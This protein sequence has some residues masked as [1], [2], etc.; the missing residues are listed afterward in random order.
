MI[1][2]LRKFFG[3]DLT[4]TALTSRINNELSYLEAIFDRSMRPIDILELPKVASFV[5]DTIRRKDEEQYD[6]LLRSIGEFTNSG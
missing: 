4:V 1:R 3:D 6:S 5:L 2:R